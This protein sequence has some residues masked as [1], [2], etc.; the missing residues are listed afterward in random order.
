MNICFN[1]YNTSMSG[2]TIDGL[3]EFIEKNNE[4]YALHS[5]YLTK[6][7]FKVDLFNKDNFLDMSQLTT[8][9]IIKFLKLEE[10]DVLIFFT[11]QSKFDQLLL[12]ISKLLNIPTIFYDHGILYGKS[13]G[14]V[15]G[16]TYEY[17]KYALKRYSYYYKNIVLLNLTIFKSNSYFNSFNNNFSHYLT[18]SLN[19][20]KFNHQ[21]FSNIE[22][23]HHILGVPFLKYK[24][25]LLKLNEIIAEKKILYI[26]QPL[27]KFK[28]SAMKFEDYMKYIENINEITK[29]N[30]YK[31]EIR[32]HPLTDVN[33]FLNF[34]WST[35]IKFDSN[36]DLN[37][38]MAQSSVVIGHWSTA[39]CLTKPLRKHLAILQFPELKKQFYNYNLIFKNVACYLPTYFELEN[40][41]IGLK[42]ER[43]LQ[44]NMD[45]W[46]NLI[47]NIYSHE[48]HSV[49]LQKVIL[50]LKQEFKLL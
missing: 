17:F 35:N 18:F 21:F 16:I 39:L 40:Y 15:G 36:I 38:Q 43:L 5:N 27:V 1:L 42:E 23:N 11:F 33:S 29:K 19:N 12:K 20:K 26:H 13:A 24:N 28:Y 22:A 7:R 32:L 45:Q 25:E 8:Y 9:Q 14:K 44:K 3:S 30:N 46:E 2:Y 50:K 31:L 34:K 49:I 48:E 41:L 10:I 4:I 47:G 6:D 37:T